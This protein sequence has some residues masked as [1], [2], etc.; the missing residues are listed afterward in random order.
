[1]VADFDGDGR[2]D[3]VLVAQGS[4]PQLLHNSFVPTPRMPHEP[5]WIE[6]VVDGDGVRVNRDAVG[7]RVELRAHDEAARSGAKVA[8]VA[9]TGAHVP[10][11]QFREIS[12]GNGM[13]AQ[14]MRWVHAGF[15]SY[16][17]PIDVV[18]RWTDGTV[19]KLDALASNA[20]YHVV[21]GALAVQV[22]R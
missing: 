13:S 10:L 8:E 2:P 14:S 5:H 15:G 21:Y 1:V 11:P 3:I 7:V 18:V 9:A 17:G 16:E 12:A 20:R 19:T 6:L 4:A 22:L